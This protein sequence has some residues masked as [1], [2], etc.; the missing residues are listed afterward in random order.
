MPVIVMKPGGLDWDGV[1][2]P[3]GAKMPSEVRNHPSYPVLLAVNY[4]VERSGKKKLKEKSKKSTKK[5][6]V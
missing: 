2:Y 1:H 6:N 3:Q 4:V 5:R